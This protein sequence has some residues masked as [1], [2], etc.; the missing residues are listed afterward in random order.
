MFTT[1]SGHLAVVQTSWTEWATY[2]SFD[3]YGTEGVI[4]VNNRLPAVR[5]TLVQRR[6]A[7]QIFDFDQIRNSYDF[8]LAAYVDARTAGIAPEP[9]GLDGMRAVEMADAV[10]RSARLGQSVIV[11]GSAVAE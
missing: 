6:G 3:V 11:A 5:T 1:E 7:T 10:Y 9:S 8:E 2:F 4:I